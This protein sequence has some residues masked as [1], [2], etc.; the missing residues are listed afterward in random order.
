MCVP[1]LDLHLTYFLILISIYTENGVVLR[2]QLY[3]K[4]KNSF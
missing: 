4:W 2:L 1:Y 3:R